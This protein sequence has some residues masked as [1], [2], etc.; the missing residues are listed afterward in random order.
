MKKIIVGLAILS[1][2]SA[3]ADTPKLE[4]VYSKVKDIAAQYCPIQPN[5]IDENL[6]IEDRYVASG[7]MVSFRKQ[8]VDEF[9]ECAI[10]ARGKNLANSE[11]GLGRTIM[12]ITRDIMIHCYNQKVTL[13][14]H[15]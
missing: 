2:I 5:E 10:G 13:Q 3:F 9:G 14:V 1:S 8:L 4:T 15:E 11:L 12:E 7:F 6:S